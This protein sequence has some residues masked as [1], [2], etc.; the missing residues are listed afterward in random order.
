[1]QIGNLMMTKT[2][3]LISVFSDYDEPRDNLYALG[4][5]VRTV[6][7][8]LESVSEAGFDDFDRCFQE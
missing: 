7:L 4:A 1:L 2:S 8:P 6:A 3:R 5:P